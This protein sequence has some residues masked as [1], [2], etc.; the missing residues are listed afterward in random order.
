MFE[1]QGLLSRPN[2]FLRLFCK[3]EREM[4]NRNLHLDS[5]YSTYPPSP[6]FLF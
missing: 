4:L 2:L 3:P 5:L 6:D 1:K